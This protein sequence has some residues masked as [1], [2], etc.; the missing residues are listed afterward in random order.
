MPEQKGNIK[1]QVISKMDDFCKRKF[2]EIEFSTEG[3]L[4]ETY[5]YMSLSD[6]KK[7]LE[8]CFEETYKLLKK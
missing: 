1:A 3:S 8:A 7:S 4:T 6:V 2:E 5:K